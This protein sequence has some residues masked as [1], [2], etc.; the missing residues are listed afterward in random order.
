MTWLHM[1]VLCIRM[2]M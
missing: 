1:T 2:F